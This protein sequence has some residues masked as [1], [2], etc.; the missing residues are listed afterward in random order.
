[1]SQTFKA[2]SLTQPW[3]TLVVTG[4]KRVETR[5]W[6]TPYRGWLGIHASKSFPR[7]AREMCLEEPFYSALHGRRPDE[8][9]RGALIGGVMLLDCVPTAGLEIVGISDRER[10]FG[11][12][13]H[14]R[15]GWLLDQATVFESRPMRGALGL[16]TIPSS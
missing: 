10:A 11:D 9:S 4:A 12:Y 16:W 15:Y 2:L 7:W 3:A 1:M 5:S 8:L 13:E 6:R 14:G